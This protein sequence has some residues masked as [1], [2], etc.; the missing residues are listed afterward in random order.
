MRKRR[1]GLS[2]SGVGATIGY[3]ASGRGSGVA[4]ARVR[5]AEGEH[6]VRVPFRVDPRS[7][8]ASRETGYAALTA[9]VHALHERG[10][11][12]VTFALADADLIED[13]TAHRAVP[14]SIVIPYVRLRCALNQLVAFALEFATESDLAQRARAEVELNVAA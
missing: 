3:A 5:A 11:G 8:F 6:L 13:V 9:I 12:R 1:T 7:T 2:T 4:Y 14:P 10:L